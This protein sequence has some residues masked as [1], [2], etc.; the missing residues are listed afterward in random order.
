MEQ[1]KIN[2]KKRFY[3]VLIFILII[4]ISLF[5]FQNYSQKNTTLTQ[6]SPQGD[7]QMMGYLIKT[8][9]GKLI[10]IDG[11]T[12]D[13]KDQLIDQ[14]NQNGG[15]VDAWFLTHAHDDHVGAFT[16]IVNNT[17]ILINKIYVSTN[18][19]SWYKQYEPQRA[20][21]TEYFLETL[22][23]EKIKDKVVQPNINDIFKIDNVQAEILGI[24]NPEI[25]E[26]PGNE[27]SMVIKFTTNNK[28][29]LILGDTG[30]KSSEKLLKTQKEKLKSDI[31]QIAHHGQQGAT[32][33]LYKQVNPKICLWPTPE[34][35]WNNDIG[36]GENT[37]PYKTFETREWIKEMNVK[38]NYIAKDGN[39][40]INLF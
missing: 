5:Y 7:R 26:N 33:E 11:G 27:Q 14:I 38:E 39:I 15:K 18:E 22:E 25:T 1:K 12:T 40:T 31:L 2:N 28:S 37:G 4:A 32:K 6:L 9:K 3:V 8:H 19:L 30:E 35:L 24:K 13:D 16:Q 10:V 21:F 23:S 17:D 29:L 36:Q 20:D 34:W